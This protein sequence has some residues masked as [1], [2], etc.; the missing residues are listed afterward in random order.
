MELD[1]SLHHTHSLVHWAV[2]VMLGEGVLLEE[3]VLDNLGRLN[4]Q[5][6]LDLTFKIAF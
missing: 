5:Q 6:K 3:F 4:C 2:V 1:N